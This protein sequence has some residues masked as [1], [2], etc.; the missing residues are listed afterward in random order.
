MSSVKLLKPLL[1]PINQCYR[2][3]E[4]C[5]VDNVTMADMLQYNC[6]FV[7]LF[8]LCK[9]NEPNHIGFSKCLLYQES[10]LPA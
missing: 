10:Y 9:L 1:I 6:M 2:Q 5:F 3:L 4:T 7:Q 8:V